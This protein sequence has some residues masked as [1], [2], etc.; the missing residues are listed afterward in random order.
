MQQICWIAT[1]LA[2]LIAAAFGSGAASAQTLSVQSVTAP[3]AEPA[4]TVG[5]VADGAGSTS[6]RLVSELAATAVSK[7]RIVP[8][9]GVGPLQN[10]SDLLNLKGVDAAVVQ[11]DVLE[12]A[13][14]NALHE[15]MDKRVRF[16]ARLH[17]RE[18]HLIAREE[19]SDVAA[20]D[21]RRVNVGPAGAGLAIT[22][23]AVFD[24]AGVAVVA[25]THQH[26]DAVHLIKTGQI[27]A[28]FYV[29]GK[30]V[31]MFEHFDPAD[32]LKL[33]TVPYS[34][35]LDG[36]YRPGEI[37]QREYPGLMHSTKVIETISVGTVLVGYNWPDGSEGHQRAA[38]FAGALVGSLQGLAV[39]LRHSKWRSVNLAA[40]EPGWT[41]HAAM[42][43]HLGANVKTAD[44]SPKLERLRESFITVLKGDR[45]A[46]ADE[47]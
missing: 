1:C 21:G 4:R 37:H 18:V 14:I 28:M 19:F 11:S 30:P 6:L 20:L 38:L 8:I 33:L 47:Q 16:I 27:D 24:A 40:V 22:A 36:H 46:D 32:G 35:G 17:N 31:P 2:V 23:Q 3:A 12:F 43:P 45:S 25:T 10:L 41:R 34:S 15:D 9:A 39:D 13:K 7:A 5:I 29:G 44:H 42:V 26:R